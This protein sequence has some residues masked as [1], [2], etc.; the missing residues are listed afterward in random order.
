MVFLVF[1]LLA[2]FDDKK[3]THFCC[4]LIKKRKERTYLVLVTFLYSGDFV[5]SNDASGCHVPVCSDE[6]YANKCQEQGRMS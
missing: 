6:T 5:L 3:K 1:L 4:H 2:Q